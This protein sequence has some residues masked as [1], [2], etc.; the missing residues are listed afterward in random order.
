[1]HGITNL[2]FSDLNEKSDN[3]NKKIDTLDLTN[4]FNNINKKIDTLDLTNKFYQIL[5]KLDD[6]DDKISK[7]EKKDYSIILM[8]IPLLFS[9]GFYFVKNLKL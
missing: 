7:S 2:K 8:S 4:K 6:I 9:I 1:M 3:I 5:S